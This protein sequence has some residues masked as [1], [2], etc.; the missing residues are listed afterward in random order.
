MVWIQGNM[1]ICTKRNWMVKSNYMSKIRLQKYIKPKKVLNN[2]TKM[3]LSLSKISSKDQQIVLNMLQITH[4]SF[5]A[6]TILTELSSQVKTIILER[7]WIKNI[8]KS[9]I[10]SYTAT[11][12]KNNSRW[13][14]WNSKLATQ[15]LTY[16]LQFKVEMTKIKPQEPIIKKER[17][18]KEKNQRKL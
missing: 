15:Q 4:H 17:K 11:T 2:N 5:Q 16:T 9:M 13:S 18:V 8:K 7:H 12:S 10:T 1:K 3:G 14:T 6:L